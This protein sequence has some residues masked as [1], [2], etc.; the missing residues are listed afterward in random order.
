MSQTQSNITLRA[1]ARRAVMALAI[2]T[3]SVVASK[4]AVVSAFAPMVER[5][6][7]VTSCRLAWAGV[8]IETV[9]L[10]D[11]NCADHIR[12]SGAE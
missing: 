9:T 7:E 4:Y 2:V 5:S 10:N 6:A 12:H 11:P 1:W 8:D 3:V